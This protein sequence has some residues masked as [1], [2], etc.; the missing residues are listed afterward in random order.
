[1]SH[2][3]LGEGTSRLPKQLEEQHQSNGHVKET[4]ELA[5]AMLVVGAV[6]RPFT[7]AELKTPYNMHAGRLLTEYSTLC[8][9]AWSSCWY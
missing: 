7:L 1:M 4:S 8:C 6:H 2:K 9:H 3:Q 5:A